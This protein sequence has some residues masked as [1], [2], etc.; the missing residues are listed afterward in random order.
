MYIFYVIQD[1]LFYIFLY[2]L[3]ILHAK[4]FL[5]CYSKRFFF[6]LQML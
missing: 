6:D 3:C 5:V 2:L 1:T 4:D